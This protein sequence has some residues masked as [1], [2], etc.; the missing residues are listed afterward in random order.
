MPISPRLSKAY[1]STI[2][3]VIDKNI[4]VIL[5]QPGA[6]GPDTLARLH[7][8]HHV[9]SSALLTAYN[10]YSEKTDNAA[11]AR[12]QAA[13][14]KDIKGHWE[15]LQG[16]GCDPA[17]IWPPEPSIL[18]FGISLEEART[19]AQKYRQNAVVWG[20]AQGRTH[21]IAGDPAEQCMAHR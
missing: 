16:E 5:P 18:M 21:L 17:G 9:K 15:F 3:K 10:P 13:L 20:G 1:F 7:E 19:L 4:K 11:N 8:R 12:A 14:I 6:D 2:F